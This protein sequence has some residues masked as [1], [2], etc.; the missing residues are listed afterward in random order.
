VVVREKKMFEVLRR[1][2]CVPPRQGNTFAECVDRWLAFKGRNW[3]P[4]TL[5]QVGVIAR[6]WKERLGAIRL[7][8]VRP[9]DVQGLYEE[10]DDGTRAPA[11]V[12]LDRR[13]FRA[14]WKWALERELAEHN[15]TAAWPRKRGGGKR[16]YLQIPR[17]DQELIERQLKPR[18]LRW[19]LFIVATGLRQGE[20]RKIIWRWISV[21]GVLQF[22]WEARKQK[23]EH[24]MALPRR[25][26]E[27]LG[28][29]GAE[30]DLVFP[31]IPKTRQSLNRV[32]K[33]AGRKA[34]L[35][36]W[37]T[38]SSHQFRRTWYGRMRRAGTP[39]EA[40]QN[41][42]GWKSRSIMETHYWSPISDE[43]CRSYLERI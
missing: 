18:Y 11:T 15:P 16:V 33:R 32:L 5:L 1:H 37:R 38:I 20:S 7:D 35:D 22:P 28:P 12:N 39:T 3:E 27:A 31:D 6:R 23:R 17:E 4:G 40:C 8:E 34:G 36:Y 41:I 43:E 29:R 9:L 14:F 24:R 19:L 10:R 21:A 26:V 30:E 25:V 2:E 42:G 13:Y